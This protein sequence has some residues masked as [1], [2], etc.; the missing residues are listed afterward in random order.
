MKDLTKGSPIKLILMFMLP[1]LVGNLFQQ[2]Y[3]TIDMIIVGQT[4]GTQAV[5]AIGATNS[6]NFLILGFA[7]GLTSGLSILT[8]QR[9]GA[10]DYEGVRKSFAAS[11]LISLATTIVLTILSTLFVRQILELMQTPPELI[12]QA[13]AFIT[14]LFVGLFAAVAFNLLSNVLRALGNARAPLIFLIVASI[15]NILLDYF[16]I[17]VMNMNTG[18]VGLATIGAQ[19]SAT[20]LCLI[21]IRKKLPELH[22]TWSDFKVGKEELMT[23]ARIAYPMAFQMSIIAIGTVV[24]QIAINA[25]GTDAVAATTAASKIDQYIF[26][27]M[28]SFGLTLATFAAQNYGAKKYERIIQAIKQGLMLCVG[29]ALIAGVLILRFGQYFAKLLLGGYDPNVFAL[30]QTYFIVN[31]SMYWL[32]A[33][34]FILRSTLQGLGNSATPTIAGI[35]ELIMRVAAAIFLP[36]FFGYAGAVAA[37]PLAWFGAVVVLVY[38]TVHS[39]RKLRSMEKTRWANQFDQAITPTEQEIQEIPLFTEEKSAHS[40]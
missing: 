36:L 10:Q 23:H 5:A 19:L 27:P 9:F 11:I 18:G 7:I 4:L 12:D 25:L 6:I 24:L 32:L 28:V 26:L 31:A 20:F 39:M 40:L 1:L 2:L 35:M 22:L 21:Y 38:S 14:V 37:N 29:F 3:L 8:A 13:Q 16:F 17:L 33:I 34:L 30:I 15:V